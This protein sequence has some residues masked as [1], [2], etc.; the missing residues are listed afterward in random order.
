MLEE[1]K[2]YETLILELTNLDIHTNGKL[3]KIQRMQ[4]ENYKKIYQ[5]LKRNYNAINKAQ[6]V[7]EHIDKSK[8]DGM[9]K[10]ILIMAINEIIYSLNGK[11]VK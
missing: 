10:S 9:T 6:E 7:K 3:N 1:I 2:M 8:F 5:F 11:E 4:L